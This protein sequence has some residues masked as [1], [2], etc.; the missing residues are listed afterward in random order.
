MNLLNVKK[1]IL[2]SYSRKIILEIFKGAP[3]NAIFFISKM[4]L[5]RL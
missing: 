1:Q 5:N 3:K 4:K 2:F